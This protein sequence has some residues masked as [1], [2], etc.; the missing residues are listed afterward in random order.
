MLCVYMA[1]YCKIV[2]ITVIF[3]LTYEFWT[4]V[5]FATRDNMFYSKIV[6][7]HSKMHRHTT[8]HVVDTVFHFTATKDDLNNLYSVAVSQSSPRWKCND[9]LSR[10]S[11]TDTM[12][13]L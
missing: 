5:K 8:I 12:S 11:F 6:C 10:G 9:L 4:I 2:N 7:A 1:E 13:C 3:L